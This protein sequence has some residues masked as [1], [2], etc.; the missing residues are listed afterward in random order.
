MFCTNK[1]CI[2]DLPHDLMMISP[3][4]TISKDIKL[5][6]NETNNQFRDYQPHIK[7]IGVL[8]THTINNQYTIKYNDG[9]HNLGIH[10][11]I[12]KLTPRQQISN[13][14][15]L[16]TAPE[17]ILSLPQL[18]REIAPTTEADAEVMAAL[19]KAAIAKANAEEAASKKQMQRDIVEQLKLEEETAQLLVNKLRRKH[20][21]QQ[22]NNLVTVE[23]ITS[24]IE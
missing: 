9:E 10:E 23:E 7:I 8:D 5:I 24:E 11:A 21:N 2:I 17:K 22:V 14:D 1:I 18:A 12:K 16:R 6:N 20:P 4:A 15:N 19:K 3:V 13:R